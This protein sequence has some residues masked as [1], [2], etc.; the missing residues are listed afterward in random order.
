MA[1]ESLL[2]DNKHK[3]LLDATKILTGIR[4]YGQVREN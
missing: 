1:E 3:H 2:P 4:L